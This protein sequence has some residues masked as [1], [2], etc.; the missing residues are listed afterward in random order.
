MYKE[1]IEPTTAPYIPASDLIF[2]LQ[3]DNPV[4]NGTPAR[5]A[6]LV[7]MATRILTGGS[8]NVTGSISY[9]SKSTYDLLPTEDYKVEEYDVSSSTCINSSTSYN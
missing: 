4:T 7:S 8:D 3:F 6:V 9:R 1:A 2:G 5:D